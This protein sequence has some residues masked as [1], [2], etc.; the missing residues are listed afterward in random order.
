[1]R[2]DVG[3]IELHCNLKVFRRFAGIAA[4]L[5]NLIAQSIA[6]Q[7]ALRIFGHHLSE[8]VQ[9]HCD[10]QKNNLRNDTIGGNWTTS[11]IGS[12]SQL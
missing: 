4:L 11:P 8:C 1:M 10:V 9:V 6:A 3:W 7:K 2:G 12:D 5:Q